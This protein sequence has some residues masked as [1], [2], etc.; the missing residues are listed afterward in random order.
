VGEILF[1][2]S[3]ILDLF[4]HNHYI[5]IISSIGIDNYCNTINLNANTMAGVVVRKIN[6][7]KFIIFTDILGILE[8]LENLDSLIKKTNIE[9]NTQIY[10]RRHCT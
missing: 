5:F 9:S 3:E 4:T 2:Y 10:R 8:N 1:S 6:T 7:E